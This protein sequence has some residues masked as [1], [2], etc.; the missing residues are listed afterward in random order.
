[1]KNMGLCL[2]M[3]EYYMHSQKSHRTLEGLQGTPFEKH[4]CIIIFINGTPQS[5][6][7]QDI[8]QSGRFQKNL[9]GEMLN[10]QFIY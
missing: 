7:V 6:P 3:R 10:D 1:M 8:K 9:F 5:W 2:S 4:W